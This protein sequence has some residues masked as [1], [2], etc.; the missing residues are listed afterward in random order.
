MRYRKR[1]RDIEEVARCYMLKTGFLGAEPLS[2][3]VSGG[4]KPP[5]KLTNNQ[6]I[7][8][9]E[10]NEIIGFPE[11]KRCKDNTTKDK[12]GLLSFMFH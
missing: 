3:G 1:K 7:K 9:K 4:A 11:L 12:L 8:I 10:N 2:G 6:N 5:V